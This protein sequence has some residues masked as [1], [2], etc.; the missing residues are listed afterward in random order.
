MLTIRKP[1]IALAALAA[2]GFVA[3]DMAES[4]ARDPSAASTVAARFPGPAETLAAHNMGRLEQAPV[5]VAKPVQA[6][7][8]VPAACAHEHWPYVA[9]EC[10]A[11]PEGVKKQPARVIPIERR[12]AQ[13]NPVTFN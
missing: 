10:L 13:S 7:R 4:Q 12:L 6:E 3:I 11:L 5:S 9:D 8:I 1:L 2:I